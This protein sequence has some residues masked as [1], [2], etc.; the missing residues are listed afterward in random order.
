MDSCVFSLF[1]P[2]PRGD[3]QPLDPTQLLVRTARARDL[4]SLAEILALS[5]HPPDG[6]LSLAYP[7]LKL[8]IQEDLR[9]RLRAGSPHY[10][11]FA[12]IALPTTA[13]VESAECVAGTVEIGLRSLRSRSQQYPYISN[14]AVSQAYRRQGVARRLLGQCEPL[15]LE[16]GYQ[17]LYLHVLET[18][19]EAKMLYQSCGYQIEQTESTWA[20]QLLGQPRRLL[21]RKRLAPASRSVAATS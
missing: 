16:W 3:R 10:C 17:D 14:L 4:N 19:R 15:A 20:A 1:R 12:A 8:G 11:C 5:F 21:L 2:A 6:W 18:N 7:F 9:L 13:G